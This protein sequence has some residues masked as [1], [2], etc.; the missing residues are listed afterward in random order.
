MAYFIFNGIDSRDNKVGVKA[1][2]PRVKPKE[3]VDIIQVPGR[4]GFLSQ[5]DGTY[6][7]LSLIVEC[8][9]KKDADVH[10]VSNWLKGSGKLVL[11]DDLDKE[12]DVYIV[13]AIPFERVFRHWK[14]FVIQFEA[15]PF[16]KGT[17][18]EEITITA[19]DTSEEATVGGNMHT[20]PVITINGTGDFTITVNDTSIA[21]TGVDEAIVIDNEMMNCTENGG[22]VNANSKMTG[23][24]VEL[25]PGENTISIT[26]DDGAFTE[27]KFEYQ[28]TWI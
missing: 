2:P 13:N 1:L 11:S 14:N 16:A 19:P 17:V 20:K 5:S 26:V 27:L 4:N 6:D 18:T 24:F 8:W 15:Q 23:N 9:L 25:V 7:S 22:T 21:L 28:E 3:R 12:Y 10:E